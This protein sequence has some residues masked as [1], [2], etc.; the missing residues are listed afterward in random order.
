MDLEG[1]HALKFIDNIKQKRRNLQLFSKNYDAFLYFKFNTP[2]IY[3]LVGN[4]KK[5]YLGESV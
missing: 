1:K 3:S 2:E 4:G 5:L